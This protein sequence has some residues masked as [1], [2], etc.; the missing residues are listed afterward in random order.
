MGNNWYDEFNSV[1][2]TGIATMAFGALALLV[3]YGFASKCDNVSICFGMLRIHR[4]VELEDN[5]E[6]GK[7]ELEAEYHGKEEES[8]ANTV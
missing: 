4:A 6:E 8:K 3:R 1:F 2:F 5:I 7:D